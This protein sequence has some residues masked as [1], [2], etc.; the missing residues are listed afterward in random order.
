M[1]Q[2]IE[3]SFSTKGHFHNRQVSIKTDPQDSLEDLQ[4]RESSAPFMK[5]HVRKKRASATLPR[6]DIDMEFYSNQ[7]EPEQK[8]LMKN[9]KSRS[10]T[11]NTRVDEANQN[12]NAGTL[13]PQKV[14]LEDLSKALSE[15]IPKRIQT[16]PSSSDRSKGSN[17]SFSL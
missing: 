10:D 5:K 17:N 4:L 7:M 16:P 8:E 14:N 12:Q 9:T 2:T 15:M 6:F 3:S 11:A 13:E 1:S